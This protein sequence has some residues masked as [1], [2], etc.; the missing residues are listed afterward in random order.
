MFTRYLSG[1]MLWLW[2][3]ITLLHQQ[4]PTVHNAPTIASL[5]FY[6]S[7]RRS[8]IVAAVLILLFNWTCYAAGLSL[9]A[10]YNGVARCDITR[11]SE[12]ILTNANQ[13]GDGTERM[14]ERE[15][16]R[17]R[18]SFSLRVNLTE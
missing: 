15:R 5:Y 1:V 13:V 10:F 7:L 9:F 6:C 11:P 17:Q 8:L 16:D 2:H 12:R 18:E 4:Y 3:K 14:R